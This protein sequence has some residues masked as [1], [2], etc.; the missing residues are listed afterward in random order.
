MDEGKNMQIPLF[1][2]YVT[3]TQLEDVMN[4][5]NEVMKNMPKTKSPPANFN[6]DEDLKTW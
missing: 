5:V 2:K 1:L 4:F 3:P 6:E